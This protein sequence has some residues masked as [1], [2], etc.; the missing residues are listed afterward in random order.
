MKEELYTELRTISNTELQIE[1]ITDKTI[2]SEVLEFESKNSLLKYIDRL[3]KNLHT[4][5]MS[6]CI[7]DDIRNI[8]Y[9][10][11]LDNTEHQE[12]HTVEKRLRGDNLRFIPKTMVKV[13]KSSKDIKKE[14]IESI[15]MDISVGNLEVAKDELEKLFG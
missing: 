4:T 1:V 11:N 12:S 14:K 15:M 6:L 2:N 3:R 9:K 13:E 7:I 10:F 5:N 8:T